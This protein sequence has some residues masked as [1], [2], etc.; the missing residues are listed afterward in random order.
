MHVRNVKNTNK[1]NK[2]YSPFIITIHMLLDHLF[3]LS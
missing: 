2:P 1:C 3:S